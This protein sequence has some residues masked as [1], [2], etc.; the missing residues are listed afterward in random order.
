MSKYNVGDVVR[1]ASAEDIERRGR[2]DLGAA[3]P[4]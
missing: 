1:I 4:P 2:Y 3:A